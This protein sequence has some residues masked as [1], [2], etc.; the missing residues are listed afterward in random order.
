[1]DRVAPFLVSRFCTQPAVITETCRLMSM[2][3][4]TFISMT[5]PKTYPQLFANCEHKVLQ[6]IAKELEVPIHGLYFPDSAQI[7]AYVFQLQA[8][9]QTQKALK[10]IGDMVANNLEEGTVVTSKQLV[11]M[12]L[13][14]LLAEL[15]VE[16]GHSHKAANV[17]TL[18]VS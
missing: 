9:G 6:R 7:L 2:S 11:K 4:A 8:P 12:C 15:V 13:V 17:S 5:R 14:P 18:F 3:M 1:M 16:T 10:F